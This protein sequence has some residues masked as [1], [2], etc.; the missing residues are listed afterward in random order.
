[1]PRRALRPSF[2]VTLALGAT[3]MAGGCG[4]N[5]S[6][7][8]P[9]PSGIVSSNPPGPSADGGDNGDGGNVEGGNGGGGLLDGSSVG[10]PAEPPATG[11]P[12]NLPSSASCSYPS[13]PCNGLPVNYTLVCQQ[14]TWIALHVCPV[15]DAGGFDE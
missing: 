8:G 7:N 13:A 9:G 12:C 1:M 6:G 3:A 15:Y 10:C 4:G 2:V 14:G 5:D 11:A